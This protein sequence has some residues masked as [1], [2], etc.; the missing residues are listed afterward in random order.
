MKQILAV[1]ALVFSALPSANASPI[2]LAMQL[3]E[4]A[5]SAMIGYRLN[6]KYSVEAHYYRAD[7]QITHAGVN[8]DTTTIG[9]GVVGVAQFPMK[10]RDVLPY[11]LFIKTG[12]EHTRK[13]EQYSIPS[14]VT[15]TLPYTGEVNNKR[16]QVIVGGGADYDF[17]RSIRGRMGI[18]FV[19]SSKFINLGV[20]Y[21]F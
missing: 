1:S 15:L 13:D 14:S 21:Q 4:T 18:D 10:L 8:V 12:Y 6:A 11:F 9:T 16:N 17:T 3:G 2:Y 7:S 19:G 5:A 20:I